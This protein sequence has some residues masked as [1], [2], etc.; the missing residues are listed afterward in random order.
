MVKYNFCIKIGVPTRSQ[1]KKWGDYYL[2]K[3]LS[4]EL[5]RNGHKC[6]IQ[7]LPEWDLGEDSQDDIVIHFRGLSRYKVKPGHFN[8]MWNISH[9]DDISIEEFEQY[10]MVLVSSQMFAEQLKNKIR[11]PVEVFLQ[12]TDL[13][14]F[15]PKLNDELRFPLLFVGNSRGVYRKIVKDA[16]EA[17]D[18]LKIIGSGWED[19]IQKS[20]FIQDG[21]LMKN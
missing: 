2:A 1:L 17:S 8:I 15:Y 20:I 4:D 6:H 5:I 12:F 14:V 18:E 7:I 13:S 16:S 9:P 11:V 21:S 3:S 19:I 10:D